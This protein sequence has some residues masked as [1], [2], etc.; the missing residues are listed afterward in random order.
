[1]AIDRTHHHKLLECIGCSYFFPFARI[2][3]GECVLVHE[4]IYVAQNKLIRI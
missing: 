4:S 3:D 1:M 2:D